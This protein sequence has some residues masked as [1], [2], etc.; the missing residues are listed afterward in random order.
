MENMTFQ[1]LTTQYAHLIAEAEE[2]KGVWQL[3]CS[4]D[5]LRP[6][7]EAL[8]S[9]FSFPEE[10]TCIDEGEELRLYY[11]LVNLANGQLLQLQVCGL[12]KKNSRVPTACDLW[13]GFD[14]QEREVF[15]L[16][17]V[18]FV[19]HPDLR[20]IVSWEGIVGHPLLKEFKIDN[21]D[22]SW[23]IPEQTDSEIIELLSRP[24]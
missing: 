17:G 22:S 2:V 11:R 13:R 18:T 19:G 14:W 4:L 9:H 5:S 7:L 12:P 23:Q 8:H 24:D 10:L 20:R 6:L 15:D 16:F 3:C 21:E 1:Q